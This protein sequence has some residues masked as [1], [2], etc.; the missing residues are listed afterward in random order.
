M[1]IA[2]FKPVADRALL[3]ELGTQVDDAINRQIIALDQKIAGANI[4]GLIET[5]PAMVNLLVVFD[6]L[7]TDHET[8]QRRVE[9][10]FP[11]EDAG[12]T[13]GKTH[14]LNICYD[15]ELSPDLEAVAQA[16]GLSKEAVINA[17]SRAQYRVSMYGFVPGFAYLSGVPDDIQVPR[18]TNPVRDIPAGSVIIAGPQCLTT[19]LKMPTGW[20][21]IGRSDAD[22]LTGNSD[23]PFLFDVGDTVTFNRVRRD[24][25]GWIET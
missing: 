12:A 8:V 13:G 6:P 24:D 23:K 4:E 18:K 15:S 25:L 5:V 9:T 20:S 11:L 16:V 19:T 10:L 2:N 22:I 14:R 17:H 21:I 3:V 1:E 7:I